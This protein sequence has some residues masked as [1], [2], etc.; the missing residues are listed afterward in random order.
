VTPEAK[1]AVKAIPQEEGESR[2]ALVI[3]KANEMR[4]MCPQK[5]Y[6]FGARSVG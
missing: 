6:W 4:R 1:A 5:M 3:R 2:F